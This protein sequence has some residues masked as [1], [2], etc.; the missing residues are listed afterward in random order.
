MSIVAN[1][2][3]LEQVV[4]NMCDVSNKTVTDIEVTAKKIQFKPDSNRPLLIYHIETNIIK[5][6]A[7]I[8]YDNIEN[9]LFDI[10]Y[11]L[12]IE[13]LDLITTLNAQD[14]SNLNELFIKYYK[15]EFGRLISQVEYTDQTEIIYQK[16][17]KLV[18]NKDELKKLLIQYYQSKLKSL[19]NNKSK[20]TDLDKALHI[21]K[22]LYKLDKSQNTK[23]LFTPLEQQMGDLVQLRQQKI[24]EIQSMTE[25]Q[26][27]MFRISNKVNN[28]ELKQDQKIIEAISNRLKKLEKNA[29]ERKI[30]LLKG[31]KIQLQSQLKYKNDPNYYYGM[32][33]FNEIWLANLW[34]NFMKKG[35]YNPPHGHNGNFSFVLYLQVPAEL[36][37]EDESFEGSGFGPGTINFL[38][39]EQQNNIRTSHGILPV[40]NDLIIFPASLKHT[41]P[42]FKSDVE[43]ISVSGNWYI[44]D[45][46]NNKS[47]QINEEKIIISK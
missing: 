14:R 17:F 18:E 29:K 4:K 24:A 9:C 39:G 3:Y 41:V 1:V 25:K 38:Y 30:L 27:D 36:Q 37:K 13:N 45:T 33:P 12:Q 46:V 26:L 43:R 28:V 47:K 42:P 7:E 6:P 31:L 5:S 22:K 2:N 19:I 35:E 11:R 40:E 16:L 15:Q 34:I 44:T 23:D 21:F 20:Y 32:R 10:L 8:I